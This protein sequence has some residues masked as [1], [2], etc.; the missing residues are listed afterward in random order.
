M[1]FRKEFIQSYREAKQDLKW[2]LT[3]RRSYH[4]DDSVSYD[5]IRARTFNNLP[6][7]VQSQ[8]RSQKFYYIHMVLL[9]TMDLFAIRAWWYDEMGSSCVALL[10]LLL[11]AFSTLPLMS[12]IW[13][14]WQELEP[15]LVTTYAGPQLVLEYAAAF[16]FALLLISLPFL[17]LETSDQKAQRLRD[18]SVVTSDGGKLRAESK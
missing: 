12:G 14:C 13:D 3:K 17:S 18:N 10:F 5:G 16:L 6:P 15:F 2:E 4:Y 7:T 9:L 8:A 11:S 1:V